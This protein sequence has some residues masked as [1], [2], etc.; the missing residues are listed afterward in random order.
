MFDENLAI[1]TL[2]NFALTAHDNDE[3][4]LSKNVH[5]KICLKIG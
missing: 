4:L 1:D 5:Q 2:N 3:S